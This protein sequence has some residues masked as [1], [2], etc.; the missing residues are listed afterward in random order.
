MENPRAGAIIQGIGGDRMI[1]VDFVISEHI[2]LLMVYAK[3]KQVTLSDAHK[4]VV[5]ELM[6]R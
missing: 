5:R 1:Y 6:A 4:K 3:S 2:Y